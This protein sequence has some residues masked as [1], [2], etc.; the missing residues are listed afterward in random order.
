[1]GSNPIRATDFVRELARF[2]RRAAPRES[3]VAIWV[4]TFVDELDYLAALHPSTS[5]ATWG[6]DR[7]PGNRRAPT[8]DAAIVIAAVASVALN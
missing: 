1:M 3:W 4:A 7:T 6:A 8:A 5:T 2:H